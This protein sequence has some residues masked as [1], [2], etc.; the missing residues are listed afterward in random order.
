MSLST[1]SLG[2]TQNEPLTCPSSR[3]STPSLGITSAGGAV[4]ISYWNVTFNSLS[5]DHQQLANEEHALTKVGR[6]GLSTPSLGITTTSSVNALD[7]RRRCFQLPLS[8]SLDAVGYYGEQNGLEIRLRTFNSLSRDHGA[9]GWVGAV[10]RSKIAFNSLSRD[11]MSLFLSTKA[12][13]PYESFNSLSRDHL[14]MSS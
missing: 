1:P 8:G 14:F 12:A 3:L 4:D 13:L 5:R 11:H 10:V 2:I 7:S 9:V 6:F